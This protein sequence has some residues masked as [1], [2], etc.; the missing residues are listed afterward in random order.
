MS[1]LSS[2]D[3]NPL[4]QPV[5]FPVAD[6]TPPPLPSAEPMEG[7]FCRLEKLDAEHHTASLYAANSLDQDRRMW[8]YLAYGP[9]ESEDT[10]RAWV[11][12]MS[13]KSDPLF[14]A[15]VDKK[16]GRAIGVA[17]YLRIDPRAGSIE[18][19]HIAYSPLLQGT[20]AAT[21]A[22]F[23]MM[24]RAF[25]LGYRRYE[26]KCDS[27]NAPSRAAA[28]RLGFTFEGIFRQ[29]VIVKGRNRDTAWFSITDKEWPSRRDTFTRWLDPSNFDVQG[30]QHTKLSAR[31]STSPQRRSRVAAYALIHE[32]DRILLCRLSNQV[33]RWEGYWTL[34]GGGI[35]FGEE[36]AVAMVREVEE[37]TGLQVRMTS[38]AGADS[39]HRTSEDEDFHGI[40]IVYHV[41]VTGGTLT[42]E[43]E[44]STDCCE[45]HTLETA[46]GLQLVDLARTGI[47][48]L[49][50]TSR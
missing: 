46:R 29:A 36:P 8:T 44:G 33:P 34:P 20:S 3:L 16:S 45:W 5:G 9:F 28:L 49:E 22:M 41:E 37:E 6:W 30:K 47:E 21:E 4:G 13:A 23:L 50:P 7:R 48:M 26:W 24:Q 43:T 32:D 15:I 39:I 19:G 31:A 18:V 17:S 25:D 1:T 42:H 11:N 2:H 38:L 12:D 10:Y 14:F 27:L 40:R 35:E